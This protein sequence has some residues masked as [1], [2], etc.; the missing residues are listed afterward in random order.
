M[1]DKM[2][3]TTYRGRGVALVCARAWPL[4]LER[5]D[6]VTADPPAEAASRRLTGRAAATAWRGRTEGGFTYQAGRGPGWRAPAASL[7]AHF[8]NRPSNAFG[9]RWDRGH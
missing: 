2:T 9:R 1:N 4:G 5:R 7:R 3:V 6:A 8:W